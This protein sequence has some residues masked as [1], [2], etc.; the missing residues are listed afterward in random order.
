MAG[1]YASLTSPY[2]PDHMNDALRI[3]DLIGRQGQSA[4]RA[5]LAKGLMVG[6]LVGDIGGTVGN[7]FAARDQQKTQAQEAQQLADLLDS[8]KPVDLPAL[9]RAI[10][11]DRA[12]AIYP[13]LEAEVTKRKA[14]SQA[15]NETGL[16]Q[17]AAGALKQG[18]N[19]RDVAIE[20][21]GEGGPTLPAAVLPDPEVAKAAAAQKKL[22]AKNALLAQAAEAIKHGMSA[23]DAQQWYGAQTGGESL[24][25]E[26]FPEAAPKPTPAPNPTEASLALLAAQGDPAAKRALALLRAQKADGGSGSG[27]GG[28]PKMT[29]AQQEDLATMDTVVDLSGLATALGDKI[30]WKGVGGLWSGSI[31]SE[32][33]NQLGW[34]TEDQ[35]KLRNYL[36]N[37]QGTIAKLRG[38]T[39]FSVQEKAMLDTYTPNID[40][41]D[42]VI[43]SKLKSLGEF[44]ALK[45]ANTLKYANG[46][47]PLAPMPSHTPGATPGSETLPADVRARLMGT[48]PATGKPYPD[49]IYTMGNRT[50]WRKL[51]GQITEVR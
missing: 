47:Q 6:N 21:W 38:G 44:I 30:G 36:G 10:G 16:R 46:G 32:L 33:A 3:A 14:A 7:I 37:I 4:A 25:K 35:E 51:N 40:Q 39:A 24:P 29:G 50:K 23:V 20:Q 2:A 8:G 45:R 28:L 27:P 5:Q 12:R 26:W 19:P 15:A 22:D 18:A 9:I 49:G 1:P 13:L 43:Q 31:S 17:R 11:L 34:T 41:A 42:T 48:D